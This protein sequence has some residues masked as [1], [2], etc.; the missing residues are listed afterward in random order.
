MPC[1][2]TLPPTSVDATVDTPH[3]EPFEIMTVI[4]SLRMLDMLHSGGAGREQ[5]SSECKILKLNLMAR[6]VSA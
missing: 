3:I 2:N 1:T 6:R 5:G 4:F